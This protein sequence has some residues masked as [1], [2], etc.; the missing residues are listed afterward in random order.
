LYQSQAQECPY[1]ADNM[2]YDQYT[3]DD[4]ARDSGFYNTNDTMADGGGTTEAIVCASDV[5]RWLSK[6]W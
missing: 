4:L 6:V 3:L 2:G 1:L 5:T